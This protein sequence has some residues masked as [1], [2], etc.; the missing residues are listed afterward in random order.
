M[1]KSAFVP[2]HRIFALFTFLTGFALP[3]DAVADARVSEAYGKLPLHFEANRGQT[4]E[5]VRFLARGSGYSLYLTAGEA[6]L[7]LAGSNP[8]AK[9]DAH[10][11]P[12]RLS[13]PTRAT[14]V[15][16]RMGLVGAAP[17]PHVRGLEELP[18]KANYFI[19]KDPA[20]WRTN[21]PTYAKVHYREVYPGIDLLYYGNQRQL[22]YDFVVAP[23]ADPEAIALGFQGIERLEIDAEGEVVLHAG[24]GAIRQRKP[25]I[26]QEIDGNRRKIDGAYVLKGANQVAFQVAAYDRSRPLVI[27]PVLFYSTYLGGNSQDQGDGIAVDTAGNAYVTGF[28]ESINFPTTTAAFQTT[29]AGGFDAFVTKLNATGSA[30]VYSTYLGG[31][32]WDFGFAIVVDA[33]GNAYVT[34][35]TLSTNFPTTLGAFQPVFGGP[36]DAFVTKLDPA[37]SILVYSTYLGG[38]LSDI[39]FRIAVDATGNAYVAGFTES[40]NFPTTT[41]AFQTTSPGGFDAFVT[42]LNLTGSAVVYSTYLGGSNF[43][44]GTGIAVDAAGNAYVTGLTN[45]NNFPTSLGAFQPAFGGGE[46]DV[47]VTKLGPTGSG[48][49]YS[50]YFGGSNGRE[51]G[52]GIAVDATGNAYV[53]GATRSTDFPTTMG[54]FQTTYGGGN[55]DAFVA[56]FN[57][58]GSALVYSTYLGASGGDAAFGIAVDAGGNAYVT[59]QTGSTDFPTTTGA[60]QP[61]FGGGGLDAFVTKVNPLA[62]GLVYSTYLGGSGDDVG[63]G[64]AVDAMPS[65]NTY[66]TGFTGSTNFP[67]TTG[68][69]QTTFGGGSEDAF[70]TKIAD[71][72]SP[73]APTPGTVSLGGFI[74]SAGNLVGG[75]VLLLRNGPVP[76]GKATFGGNVQFRSGDPSPMGNVRYLDHVTGD[77]IKATSFDTLVI[78]TGACGPDTHAL[79]T[80]KAT[81]NGVPDQDLRIDVDDCSEPGSSQPNTPD[82][83]TIMTGP[84]QVYMN[85]GPLVGGNIQ[86][87]KAQ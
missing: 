45:S 32:D 27:D 81:V 37:G 29:L 49:V 87:K 70:V 4:H 8:D 18:G 54:A 79:I 40:I 6:V 34:G 24:G 9:R 28:T 26:Y 52:F 36:G 60:F 42:K 17:K 76:G 84:T 78:G 33:A 10:R 51:Q 30:L 75:S 5:E 41:A 66:V 12:E 31:S 62:S 68:A 69:F 16:V 53:S 20:K 61:T 35:Q 48:L 21:V 71:I 67:T 47:F 44:V 86:V 1:S 57:P 22:E 73:P 64:I 15:V 14:P 80:G 3:V 85:G 19:G 74:D 23:G 56:K 65:P 59:G 72:M 11:T 77:D 46:T 58:P 83:L 2:S 82:M 13:T 63:V 25:V 7:V 43:D 38:S 50:T 55:V 39:G